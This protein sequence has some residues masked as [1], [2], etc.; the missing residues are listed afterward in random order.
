MIEGLLW[1]R[2]S[3]MVLLLRRPSTRSILHIAGI[4]GRCLH[5]E[6]PSRSSLR[7]ACFESEIAVLS[8][9]FRRASSVCCLCFY[10]EKK[11]TVGRERHPLRV[12]G[13]HV[14]VFGMVFVTVCLKFLILKRCVKNLIV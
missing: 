5:S 4:F 7:K 13:T 9:I 10:E 3:V 1:L 6:V 11:S 12:L 14:E 2:L 8:A